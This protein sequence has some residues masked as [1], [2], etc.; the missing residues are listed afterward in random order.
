M[1]LSMDALARRDFVAIAAV[2]PAAAQTA[3][4]SQD[5]ARWI[6]ALMVQIIP[7]DDFPGAREAG[8]L[9]YLEK[10]LHS[11]L[12]RF[13]S[14]YKTGLKSFQQAHPKF[15]ELPFAEQTKLLEGISRNPFFEMLIDHTMQGFYGSPEHGGNRGEVSWKMM[16]IDKYM[17]GGHWH[18]A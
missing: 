14:D 6:D 17:G 3:F 5:D 2:A 11:A 4:F 1:I 12:S 8:C 16:G 18:G 10:Q 7:T 9:A 15:L 13:A